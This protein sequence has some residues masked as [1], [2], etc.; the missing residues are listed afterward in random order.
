MSSLIETSTEQKTFLLKCGNSSYGFGV[1]A[2]G[3]LT[4][5]HWGGRV[6]NISDLP[7]ICSLLNYPHRKP[8]RSLLVRQEYPAWGG[9]FYD[10]PVLKVSYSDGS[11]GTSLKYKAAEVSSADDHELLTVTLED[12]FYPL[13]VNLFYRIWKDIDII[14]RWSEIVN[15]GS[16]TLV[17]ERVMSCAWHM[18]RID[19]DYRLSHLAG[20]WAREGT[21]NRVPVMQNK[22]V[23]ENRTGLSG[24]FAMPFF[25][26]DEGHAAENSGRV[27]FGSLHWNGSWKIAVNR[28]AFEEVSIIGGINDF[29]FSYP[30]EPGKNFT[31]PLFSAGISDTG[32]G[33]ASRIMHD[34]Q[35]K[36]ILPEVA[37]DPIPLLVNTW[38]S[39]HADVDEQ[40]VMSVIDKAA[41]VGA[42]LFVIDDGWQAALGDWVPDPV[43]FPNGLG[44]VIDRAKELGIDFGLWVEIESFEKR[45]KLYE[46]HPEW[47][48]QYANHPPQS[49]YREDVDRTTFLIN[50][51]RKDVLEHFHKE[52]KNLLFVTG[53]TYLKLD[54]NYFF[55][56]P[57]WDQMPPE[58]ARTIWYQYATNILELFKLL[59]KEFPHV[60]IENCA[61]GCARSDLAMS[62]YFGRI[63]RSDNQDPLDIMKLHEGFT[64]MHLPGLAGGACHISDDMH[65][66]NHRDMSLTFQAA[67][68]MLGSLA[69]GKNLPKC[70]D[71][72]IAAIREWGNLYKRFRHI[73]YHGDFHR[74]VSLYNKPYAAFEYVS[75]DRGEALLFLFIRE[76]QFSTRLPMVKLQGLNPDAEY[77][78]EVHGA[79][80]IETEDIHP[81]SGR[82]LME[83]GIQSDLLG[84]HQA[85]IVYLKKI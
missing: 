34:Y 72:E 14:E 63:N 59:S 85:R 22:I 9:A 81:R 32:F 74:L 76:F 37:A 13:T 4:N 41:E 38:A 3:H 33:G 39:L 84:D 5:L 61:S 55:T 77:Q 65:H 2:D 20:R 10:E 36:H 60:R 47:V 8:E 28:D 71:E 15:N 6:D 79:P 82:S 44:P 64:W 83:I 12:D 49:K 31:T 26:V 80:V 57:G 35:R 7:D 52:M 43:K 29:D 21:I 69:I 62:R 18:P 23:L 54:M 50:F 73:T 42:E 46:E 30:L 75:K 56:D 17:L 1:N 40:S 58:K 16:E 68:G 25:A 53:I 19:G 66:V 48:M 70:P 51:A 67:A 24:P 45:S 11:R 78:L 27:W